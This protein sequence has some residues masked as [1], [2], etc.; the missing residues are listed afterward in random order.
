[1]AQTFGVT[2]KYYKARQIKNDKDG[3]PEGFAEG[4]Y[5]FQPKGNSVQYSKVNP[6]VSYE[7]GKTVEQWTI[8]F[9]DDQTKAFAVVKVRFSPT[10]QE[11]IE[12]EVELNGIPH[13]DK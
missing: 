9:Q 2:L 12:F 5:L 10:F 3:G 4:A 11:M 13:D 1:L 8:K 6:D 7:A